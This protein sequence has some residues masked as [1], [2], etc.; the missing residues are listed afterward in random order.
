MGV[1]RIGV[2]TQEVTTMAT[3][4]HS[5]APLAS[6]LGRRSLAGLQSA[7]QV[8]CFWLAVVLPFVQIVILTAGLA[9]AQVFLALLGLNVVAAPLGHGHRR[10]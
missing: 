2:T 1:A 7:L 3:S 10:G 4:S 5:P 6:S 8:A 9:N